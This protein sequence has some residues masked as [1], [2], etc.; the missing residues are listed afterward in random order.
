MHIIQKH[1]FIK[2][3]VFRNNRCQL[4]M[5]A[6]SFQCISIEL[7]ISAKLNTELEHHSRYDPRNTNNRRKAHKL[8]HERLDN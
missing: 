4:C 1:I 5:G 7:L 2:M 6:H 8:S 3:F